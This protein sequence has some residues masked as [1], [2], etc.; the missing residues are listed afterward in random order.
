[1]LPFIQRCLYVLAL[2]TIPGSLHAEGLSWTDANKDK[3]CNKNL[4]QCSYA[5]ISQID[6]PD[7]GAKA[8]TVHILVRLFP[9][10]PENY[11]NSVSIRV[12]VETADLVKRTYTQDRV[13]IT[14]EQVTNPGDNP[15]TER[16]CAYDIQLVGL[17]AI[18]VLGIDA[19]QRDDKGNILARH[20]FR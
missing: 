6:N 5:T 18:E 1:M 19:A 17:G 4:P 9:G 3:I 8:F 16:F 14:V 12:V 11:A 7:G 20:E 10:L 15:T 2:I 13:P